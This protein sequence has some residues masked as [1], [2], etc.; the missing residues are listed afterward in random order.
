MSEVDTIA[1]LV[2]GAALVPSILTDAR[3][4]QHA[5]LPGPN[6]SFI[7]QEITPAAEILKKPAFID[8]LVN[9]DQGLSLIDYVNRFKTA[10]TMIFAD[11]DELQIT[12]V[13][14]Y[15]KQQSEGPGLVEH[16]AVLQLSHSTEW[17]TWNAISG[18]MYDQKSF[19]RMLD[20]NSDDI[21]SPAAA[22]LLE[23]VMDLEM[24]SSVTVQRKLAQT[25]SSRGEGGVQ[26]KV[27]GTVL[28]AFF[29]LSLPVFTG[30]PNVEVKAMTKD[31]IDGNSGKISLGLELVRTGIIIERELARISGVIEQSTNV[32]VI[33]G[34]VKD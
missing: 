29:T 7:R 31:T 3:G 9:I 4:V 17:D 33:L 6:G 24:T 13:I 34:S 5:F 10:D 27:D 25:G 8:Q 32:P 26:R 1:K 12:A 11:L 18:R 28:P 30:E 21:A 14:D 19:A 16:R 23:T 20:I 22:T 2:T 15:H